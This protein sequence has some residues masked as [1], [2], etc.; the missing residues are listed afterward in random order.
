M[1]GLSKPSAILWL[2]AVLSGTAQFSPGALSEAEMESA[3]QL[4]ALSIPT[5]GEIFAAVGKVERPAWSQLVESQPV[6]NTSSRAQISLILGT[7][8][9][10]G[11]I[12]VEAQ[13]GQAVKNTGRDIIELA[14]GLGVSQSILARGSSLSDFAENNEWNALRE[15]LEATQNEVK[16]QMELQ[17]DADLVTLVSVG[18]WL[19]GTATLAEIVGQNYQPESAT[20][21]NQPAIASFLIDQIALLPPRLTENPLVSSSA[22]GLDKVRTLL[23]DTPGNPPDEATVLEILNI[24][25]NLVSSYSEASSEPDS[26]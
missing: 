10:D 24:T 22:E 8:V 13:D 23:L 5:P 18:A 21:L 2:A 6:P 11:F 3:A 19:R 14:K 16:L 26:K 9:C 15:E 12:A 17:K 7:R 4:D 25:R 1:N 20:L